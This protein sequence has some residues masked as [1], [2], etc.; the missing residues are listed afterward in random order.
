LTISYLA[1]RQIQGLSTDTKPI[2]VQT[3]S[4]FIETDTNG[5]EYVYD[6]TTWQL[7]DAKGV[8]SYVGY[9]AGSNFK[10]KNNITGKIDQSG[11][12]AATVINAILAVT[13]NTGQKLTLLSG[14]YPLS[15]SLNVSSLQA[16][17]GESAFGITQLRA[18]GDY[19]A[20]IVSESTGNQNRTE[21]SNLY[22]SHNF[23]TFSNTTGLI[24]LAS[25]TGHAITSTLID[26]CY[27]YDFGQNK[28]AAIKYDV[29]DAPIYK[30]TV[31][32]C[33]MYGFTDQIII[34]FTGTNANN[35][36]C[37]SNVW[38]KV[39]FWNP[40][41]TG[42]MVTAT[43]VNQ[44]FLGNSWTNCFVQSTSNTVC[45][46]DLNTNSTASQW[47]N[48]AFT[49]CLVWDLTSGKD[50]WKFNSTTEATLTSCFPSYKIGGAGA[51]NGKVVKSDTYSTQY[52]LFQTNGDG[53][54][55]AFAVTTNLPI[56]GGT[57]TPT[58]KSVV[59]EPAHQ[60]TMGFRY[61]TSTDASSFTVNFATAPPTGT[62]NVAF[63]W[64]A[65]S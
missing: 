51:T 46:F 3:N 43:S 52:R 38:D 20:I 44:G 17:S 8:S 35:S 6:G 27:F 45:G 40:N 47:S 1:G 53:S 36:F 2:N 63:Y 10:I 21:I 42:M 34:T 5:T 32:N 19:P 28:G 12:D 26:K 59:I 13:K 62:N 55:K 25:T 41:N 58:L 65:F 24:K 14:F 11:T 4:V 60:D 18:R 37:S 49:N 31:T 30:V 22:L 7:R 23:A 48:N 9:V 39:N 16:L 33:E 15:T 61:I 54:T 57:I 50:A 64:R 29:N 56:L